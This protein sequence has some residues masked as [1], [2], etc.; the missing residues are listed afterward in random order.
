[1]DSAAGHNHLTTIKEVCQ[2]L[3][4][5]FALEK[6]EGLSQC[7]TFLDITLDTECMEARL[8]S[9]KLLRIRNQLSAWLTQKRDILSL[10][11][12]LQH[13]CKVMRPGRSFMSRMYITAAKPEHLSHYTHL[14]KDFK[15]D[16][17]WWHTF[18]N[19]RNGTSLSNAPFHQ[20]NFDCFIQTDASESLG[21]V[22]SSTLT[23]F[24]MLRA[25]NGLQLIL[26]QKN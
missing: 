8:P 3:G 10:V 12:L 4:I 9:N 21:V 2:D 7:L 5:P 26:W 6:V 19:I 1:M 25:L 15:S 16:L 11:G 22:H 14:T 23:G 18:V 13:A 17:Y 20:T 24:S